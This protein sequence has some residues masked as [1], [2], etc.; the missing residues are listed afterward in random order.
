MEMLKR[1]EEL[2]AGRIPEGRL[3]EPS[4]HRDVQT[5]VQVLDAAAFP[6]ENHRVEPVIELCV[7][8]QS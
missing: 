4:P 6:A 7:V 2:P 8:T 3:S 5:A 1:V